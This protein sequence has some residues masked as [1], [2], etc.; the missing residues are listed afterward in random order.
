[1][2]VKVYK[3]FPKNQSPDD[4]RFWYYVD[5]PNKYVAKWCGAN[6]YNND[7]ATFFSSKDMKVERFK[8]KE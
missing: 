5:A 3:V 2:K 4:D 8:C 1:M 6:L 7:Y